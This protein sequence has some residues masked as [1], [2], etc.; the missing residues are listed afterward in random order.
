MN[1]LDRPKISWILIMKEP[2]MI[3]LGEVFTRVVNVEK[4][5]QRVTE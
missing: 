3:F 4:T 5:L 2:W 1:D